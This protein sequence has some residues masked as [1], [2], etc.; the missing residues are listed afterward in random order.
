M[1]TPSINAPELA[2]WASEKSWHQKQKMIRRKGGALEL[3]IPVA[4][5]RDIESWILSLG[6]HVRVLGPAALHRRIRERLVSALKPR[7]AR[8]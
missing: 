3:H 6:E 8:L 7:I 4:D 1:H 2:P 5:T